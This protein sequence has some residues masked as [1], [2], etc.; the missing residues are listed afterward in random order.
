MN[1]IRKLF[2]FERLQIVVTGASCGEAM[3]SGY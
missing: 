3:A 2:L 1:K